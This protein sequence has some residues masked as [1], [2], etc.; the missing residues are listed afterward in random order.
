MKQKG[1]SKVIEGR[2]KRKRWKMI[3]NKKGKGGIE[4]GQHL[5]FEHSVW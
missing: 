1:T 4:E 3:M 5:L 2:C